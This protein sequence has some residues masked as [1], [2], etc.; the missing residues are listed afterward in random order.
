MLVHRTAAV[1]LLALGS[2]SCLLSPDSEA[3][4]TAQRTTFSS[5]TSTA[6][7]G[8]VELELGFQQED[9]GAWQVPTNL[10]F[11]VAPSTELF[12]SIPPAISV[13]LP[14]TSPE[15]PGDL[16][17]GVRHRWREGTESR[18]SLAW[19]GTVK[20]PTADEDEG[21]GN[22]EWDL[23]FSGIAT[24]VWGDSLV[25]LF[26]GVDRLGDPDGGADW[27]QH[28]ALAVAWPMRGPW[29]AFSE[30]AGVYFEDPAPSQ[31]FATLG[32]TDHPESSLIWDFG[33]RLGLDD[34]APEDLVFLGL[35]QSLGRI[36]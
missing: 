19:Q 18:P 8:T 29:G 11:G 1:L 30:V 34:D 2:P 36:D 23:S 28:W 20:A 35:T 13:E 16:V 25:T 15:G 26:A 31:H 32:V 24:Q 21:L 14:G 27:A 22:G 7:A 17:V 3:P 5:D 9:G 12:F 10:K 4:L 33:V 6:P